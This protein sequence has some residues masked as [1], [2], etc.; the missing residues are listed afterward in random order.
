M[1]MYATTT[2]VIS[3]GTYDSSSSIIDELRSGD[4]E[5]ER[6]YDGDVDISSQDTS[7]TAAT[8]TATQY[9]YYED[10]VES[11]SVL[12]LIA[13]K[14]RRLIS[15]KRRLVR[16]KL[17][18]GLVE[19]I[20][21][22]ELQSRQNQDNKGLE[23]VVVGTKSTK[24][25]DNKDPPS[26]YMQ[27]LCNYFTS[28]FDPIYSMHAVSTKWTK[29]SPEPISVEEALQF[30]SSSGLVRSEQTLPCGSCQCRVLRTASR[31]STVAAASSRTTTT[32]R[33]GLCRV[34]PHDRQH[35]RRYRHIW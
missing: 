21:A 26:R 29:L 34:Q 10:D 6:A 24:D 14:R 17:D 20:S 18:A 11:S 7:A 1:M 25:C 33:H 35:R 3:C 13:C 22:K 27:H 30:S 9:D 19:K 8:T 32:T 15:A 5:E 16:M 4:E 28:H 12:D 2:S 31:L 23:Q